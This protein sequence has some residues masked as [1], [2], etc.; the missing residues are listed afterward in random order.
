MRQHLLFPELYSNIEEERIPVEDCFCLTL[1]FGALRVMRANKESNI[2]FMQ[3]EN[4]NAY[5]QGC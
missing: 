5:L 4:I 1:L 3:M 2:S